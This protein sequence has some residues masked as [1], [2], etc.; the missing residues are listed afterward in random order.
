MH[1]T[2]Y[3]I[4]WLYPHYGLQ[5][6]ICDRNENSICQNIMELHEKLRKDGR[7]NYV[8]LQISVKSKLVAEKW[9]RYLADYWDWQLPLL[10]KY[11][12][13]LDFKRNPVVCRDM[14]N[15]NSATQH[16][17]HVVHY[18]KEEIEHGAIIGPFVDPPIKNLHVSPFMTR[19]KSS[20]DHRRVIIDLSWP[21]GQSVNSGVDSDKYLDIE[22]V[23]TYP[24][25]DNIT[26]EVIQ[27]G[28]GCK[29]FKIDISRAFRHVPT[30]PGN[31]DLLGLHWEVYFLDQFLPFGFKHGSSIFQHFSDGIRYIMSLEGHK[32]WNYIDDFCVYPCH[33]K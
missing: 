24:S 33:L 14:A 6:P 9:A 16:P 8:G 26:D 27:L 13:P 21:L 3:P 23:L 32:V 7:H 22:F 11:G 10:V 12:F 17:E 4:I 5:N 25:I 19:D 18:L 29:I 30:D 15:H 1:A 20:S 2:E 28:K 31:L